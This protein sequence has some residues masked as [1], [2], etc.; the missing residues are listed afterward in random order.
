[1]HKNDISFYWIVAFFALAICGGLLPEHIYSNVNVMERLQGMSFKHLLGT[2]VFGRDVFLRIVRGTYNVMLVAL[3]SVCIGML[4][5][6]GVG[7]MSAYK[8]SNLRYVISGIMD[9]LFAF[10]VILLALVL[11][12]RYGSHPLIATA[13]L[14][15][16]FIPVFYRVVYMTARSLYKMDYITSARLSGLTGFEITY[17]HILSN[18]KP[19]L[20]AQFSVQLAMA[21]LAEAGLGYLGLSVKS[22]DPTWGSLLLDAQNLIFVNPWFSVPIGCVIFLTVWS[23]ISVG[24]SVY[25]NENMS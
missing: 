15:I 7:L 18:M 5:G 10:P 6:G 9:I 11:V 23:L 21:I 13:T 14:S 4:I 1:M 16:F 19:I 3:P 17:K 8:K 24:D 22:P 2:D 20:F 25:K 12:A